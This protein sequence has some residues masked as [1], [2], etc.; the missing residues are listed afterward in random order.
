M[1]KFLACS[2]LL[3]LLAVST[4]T[5]SFATDVTTQI[6][7]E[8]QKNL[9]VESDAVELAEDAES[10][11]SAQGHILTFY[12]DES[13]VNLDKIAIIA[14][15]NQFYFILNSDTERIV[16]IGKIQEDSIVIYNVTLTED[17]SVDEESEVDASR[18]V[19]PLEN[20]LD[21][22]NMEAKFN[23]DTRELVLFIPFAQLA[24]QE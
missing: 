24:D 7:D 4:F 3:S 18:Y 19:F 21:I 17:G 10:E 2:L 22:E 12:I 14:D 16:T 20:P 23:Q 5:S 15:K 1:K 9:P 11:I 13:I 8:I 6:E